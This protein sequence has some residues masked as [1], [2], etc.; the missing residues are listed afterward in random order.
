MA[1]KGLEEVPESEYT[2]STHRLAQLSEP[3]LEMAPAHLRSG[4]RQNFLIT[5]K[6]F[7]HSLTSAKRP[8]RIELR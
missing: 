3:E 2:P 5:G 8:N 6:I 7:E 1:D 4:D